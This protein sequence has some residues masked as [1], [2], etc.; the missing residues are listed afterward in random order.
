MSVTTAGVGGGGGGGG[1]GGWVAAAGAGVESCPQAVKAR[2]SESRR[3][4]AT[5][6]VSR[7]LVNEGL[8]LG[9]GRA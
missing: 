4:K 2:V 1:W 7:N 5:M 3:K 9:I 8:F 6:A